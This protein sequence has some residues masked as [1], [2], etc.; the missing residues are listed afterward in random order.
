[1]TML[2]DL[3]LEVW[4]RI[5]EF[6]CSDN[7]ALGCRSPKTLSCTWRAL[8]QPSRY[9]RHHSVA[10]RDW[11]QLCT[12]EERFKRNTE[13][14]QVGHSGIVHLYISIEDLWNVAYPE[15]D[16]DDEGDDRSDTQ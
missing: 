16:S 6:S 12:F 8:R 5:L 1:M 7:Y 13:C 11:E 14:V 9:H 3:P 15:G 2:P 10:L 4:H